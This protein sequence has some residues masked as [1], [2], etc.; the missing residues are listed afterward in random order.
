MPDLE[1]YVNEKSIPGGTIRNWDSYG[2]KI[3]KVSD[4]QKAI[5]ADPQTSGGLLIAVQP[6]GINAVKEILHQYGIQK[7]ITPIGTMI[8]KEE[9]SIKVV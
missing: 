2:E 1:N 5:L 9:I 6:A 3:G 4:Y 8:A 7:F